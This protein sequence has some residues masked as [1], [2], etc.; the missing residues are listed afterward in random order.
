[1][2]HE[3][4]VLNPSLPPSDRGLRR[5]LLESIDTYGPHLTTPVIEEQIYPQLQVGRRGPRWLGSEPPE[6]ALLKAV[7]LRVGGS[8]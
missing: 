3:M 4:K 1:M 2:A 5:S 7:V 6:S 8:R